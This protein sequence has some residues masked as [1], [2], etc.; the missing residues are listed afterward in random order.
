MNKI[1]PNNFPASNYK[2]KNI[3]YSIWLLCTFFVLLQFFLQLSSGIVIGSIMYEMRLNA[4]SASILSSSF[5]IIYTFLQ[6]PVGILADKHN[7]RTLLTLSSLTF[8]LGCL[9]FSISHTLVSLFFSRMLIG[10]GSA[11]SFVIMVHIV[12]SHYPIKYFSTLV[13]TSETLS[14]VATVIG[15][16]SMGQFI[17]Y[18]GW[19]F[20]MQITTVLAT[21]TSMLFWIKIPNSVNKN[22]TNIKYLDNLKNILSNKLLW[23]N[24][25]FIGLSFSTITVFGALWAAPF[26]QIKLACDIYTAS[27][28]NSLLFLGASIGCPLFGYLS[29]ILKKRKMLII[30][31]CLISAILFTMLIYLPCKNL[32]IN[33]IIIFTLGLSCCSYILSYAISNELSPANSLS[34]CT[35]FTNTLALATAPILQPLIGYMLDFLSYDKIYS[36]GEYQK[37]LTILPIG[38][39]IAGLLVTYLPE[40][41]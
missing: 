12:R 40:K 2:G 14:F 27:I 8:G 39:I 29:S 33:G 32:I 37:A 11:F 16:I 20:F 23:M 35:G 28:I 3:N 21:V 1:T 18:F 19:R 36:L 7:P 22:I 4:L 26:L 38:L 41:N 17:T 25:S 5:Y 6:I 13:G 9:F 24:G 15:M 30:M 31:S 34:T 10:I